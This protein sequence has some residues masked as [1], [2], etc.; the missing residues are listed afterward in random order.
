MIYTTFT[1]AISVIASNISLKIKSIVQNLR[2]PGFTY[3]E[4]LL[5][6]F[7]TS[8][9]LTIVPPL[10]QSTAF[11]NTRLNSHAEVDLAF[12]ARDVTADLLEADNKTVEIKDK[13]HTLVFKK[14][15]DTVKYTFKNKK[16]IKMV[17]NDGNI[18][19]LNRINAFNVSR[20]GKLIVIR[21][22]LIE[23]G[24]SYSKTIYL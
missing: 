24:G 11:F 20:D 2:S 7:V 19:L 22:T 4:L 23:K 10:I 18:T 14:Q 9:I 15:K 12:F 6:L 1:K 13:G 8:L 21:V 16:I 17:N 3:I 5:A